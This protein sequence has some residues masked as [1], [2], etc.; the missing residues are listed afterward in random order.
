MKLIVSI[1]RMTRAQMMTAIGTNNNFKSAELDRTR[2]VLRIYL[3]A[4]KLSVK[5]G[6]REITTC[7]THHHVL[8]I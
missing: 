3:L 1:K 7:I 6:N 8:S 5:R 4:L 2:Y